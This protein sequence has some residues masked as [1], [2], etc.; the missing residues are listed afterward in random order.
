MKIVNGIKV[1]GL[2]QKIFNLMLLFIVLL[3]GAYTAV[4]L[5]QQRSLS[6]IVQ[7][8]GAQQQAAITEV[9]E[10]TMQGVLQT[11]MTQTTAL[12]GYIANDLFDDVR[13]DV[14]TL[15]AFATG[16]FAHAELFPAVPV[17]PPSAE[18]DGKPTVMLV[19]E[20]GADPD[21]S[22]MLGLA[23]NM[24]EIMLAMFDASDKLSSVFVG[25]ADGNMVLVNDRSATYVEA[26]GTPRSLDIR[27]RP[28]YAQAAEAGELI[29]TGVELD[30][31]TD[32][33]MLECAAPVY[34]DGELVAVVSADIYLNNIA[35][36]VERSTGSGGFLCVIDGNGRVLFSSKKDGVFKVQ[37]TEDAPDL[38]E[39]EDE[40][41]AGFVTRA[42]SET[43]GLE[44]LIVD[45]EVCYMTAAPM[46]SVGWTVLSGVA[47]SVTNQP[48]E[49]MLARYDEISTQAQGLYAQGA[50]RSKQT[51]LV[52][53]VLIVALAVTGALLLAGRIVKPLEHMT[54]RINALH[55]GDTAFEMEDAYR[56]NDEIE[57]LAESF[58]TLSKRTRSYITQ[59]TRITA[60]KERIGTELALA[61]RIQADML[62][63]IFPA[64]PERP[65][66]DIYASMDPAKE[67][68]GDFYDFFLID[69]DHLGLVMADVSGKG[70]PAALFM[71]VSKILVQNY[72]MTGRSP[73]EVL[74]A[75]NDQ[76]CANNREEMFVTVWFGILNVKTGEIVAANAGHE[77]PALMRAGGHFELVRKRHGFVIGGLEGVKYREYTMTLR[78][79]D[80]LFL[81]TDGVPEAT[82]ARSEL[83]GTERMLAAL[84]ETPDA[85]PMDMIRQ[86]RR[87]VDAFVQD[88]EQFDDLTM[89][90]VEF[91]GE[92]KE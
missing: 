89:L 85:A 32:V 47:R 64:F 78:P 51:L 66:F 84:N 49:A 42:L 13:T 80:R 63:N 27:H 45:G 92:Q 44:L 48:T 81:Y 15:Q 82:N 5:W 18:N 67:V 58:A 79:G 25:T 26:D 24:G 71:M 2:Q 73:A 4:G 9:S 52:L 55:D 68:G 75:V 28:W 40:A 6:S 17:A 59:I 69:E 46:P 61:T 8:A 53:T 90:C 20:R 29:F 65:E 88:A 39:N 11:T 62:P 19:H 1:G 30:A 23:G 83:F 56:T 3:I 31:Y 33:P 41:L 57:I 70:V 76:I 87:A 34:R 12:Q 72:A 38:R 21:S 35:D 60:E 16:L 10:A 54:K 37:Y 91:L 43:T 50:E 74:Q 7:E 86:V 77:C 22:E 36:Y 14:Q